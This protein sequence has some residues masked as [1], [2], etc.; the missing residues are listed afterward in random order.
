MEKAEK[1]QTETQS[2]ELTDKK[3]KSFFD[4]NS[5][6]R[7]IAE[8]KGWE[9]IFRCLLSV[10]IGWGIYALYIAYLFHHDPS[11]ADV[12]KNSIYDFK[13]SIF[14]TLFFFGY[15]RACLALF[16]D[17]IKRNLDPKKFPTEEEKV[18]RTTKS[19]VWLSCIIYYT[20]TSILSYVLFR[21]SFFFPNLI[22]GSGTCSDI[23]KY[24][25][26]AV[27]VPYAKMFYQMQFGWHFHTLIDHVVYKWKDPKFWE[28]FLHHIVAVFLIF[29]SYLTNQVPVG[30]LVLTT[31]DP[32]DIG[33]YGSRF[34]NDRK[35][36]K[37]IILTFIYGSF[38]LA[39]M[40][41]RLFVFPKCVVGQA[42]YAFF[43]QYIHNPDLMYSIYLYMVTMMSSLVILH[44]YWFTIIIRIVIQMVVGKKEFNVY[45]NNAKKQQVK[46][47]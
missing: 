43:T 22:G 15:K 23:Y 2:K 1:I 13:Y 46:S 16:F 34:Y 29:F 31:H 24:T 27:Y 33:L 38:T 18:L 35:N 7:D 44:L 26:Y 19:C 39:W 32:C 28:M 42:L 30:I 21:D 6:L 41:L 8:F 10:F 12:P 37:D 14:P 25:P 11:F 9:L 45:D 36:K 5:I 20:F 47:Q 4:L 17:Y 40:Y 3:S